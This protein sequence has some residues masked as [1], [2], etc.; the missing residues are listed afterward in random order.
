MSIIKKIVLFL[1]FCIPLVLLSQQEPNPPAQMMEFY[2]ANSFGFE[3]KCEINS[4]VTIKKVSD[5]IPLWH[6]NDLDEQ[7]FTKHQDGSRTYIPH[8]RSFTIFANVERV[9][10]NL[11]TSNTYNYLYE[12][13]EKDNIPFYLLLNPLWRKMESHHIPENVGRNEDMIEW[14]HHIQYSD[15]LYEFVPCFLTDGERVIEGKIIEFDQEATELSKVYTFDEVTTA[16]KLVVE[17]CKQMAE[18]EIAKNI[19]A[20]IEAMLKTKSE[21]CSKVFKSNL[22]VQYFPLIYNKED[23]FD[24]MAVTAGYM[25]PK[26]SYGGKYFRCIP[27]VKP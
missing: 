20:S 22:T 7:Q 18:P 4:K 11:P 17:Q 24:K 10:R 21:V 25:H 13:L 26:A 27:L 12:D 2:C 15:D 1:N 9:N 8:D 16:R 19:F 5:I 3:Y 23:F 14:Y 6:D